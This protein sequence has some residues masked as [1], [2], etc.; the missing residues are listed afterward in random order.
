MYEVRLGTCQ[1]NEKLGERGE[2]LRESQ[3]VYVRLH[4]ATGVKTKPKFTFSG[5][6][7]SLP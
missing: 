7:I 1:N 2:Y 6:M 4:S 3:V 5:S